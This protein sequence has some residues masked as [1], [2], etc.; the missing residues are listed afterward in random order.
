MNREQLAH[1]VR[2]AATI[3]GDGDILI[4]GSQS[5]LA[6]L[7]EDRLPEAATLSVEADIAFRDD[8]DVLKADQVDG[9]IGELSSFHERYGYY[10]QGVEISTA[11]LPAGWE[12][13]AELLDR[14]DA[15]PATPRCLE[16]HDLVVSKLVAGR[17]KDLSFAAALLRSELVDP[18][19]PEER[20]R[21]IDRPGAVIHA[22]L[23]RINTCIRQASRST[24]SEDG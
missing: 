24:P 23:G 3:V 19:V 18:R 21:T 11:V 7:D 13:R 12:E 9:S 8:P 1:I 16:A 17:E 10:A 15:Y 5:I 4:L 6:T 22:V 20:A 14:P 2:A